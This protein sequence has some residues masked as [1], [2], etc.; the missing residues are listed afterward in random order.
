ME[1]RSARAAQLA[2]QV[3]EQTVSSVNVAAPLTVNAPIMGPTE[4]VR[5]VL[6]PP[7]TIRTFAA[8]ANFLAESYIKEIRSAWKTGDYSEADRL[9][10]INDS[11]SS[12]VQMQMRLRAPT[13]DPDELLQSILK[14]YGVHKTLSELE[15]EFYAVHQNSRESVED[16]FYRL[17]ALYEKIVQQ[18]R[19]QGVQRMSEATVRDRLSHN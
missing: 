13:N 4:V 16:Y 9:E 10:M 18:Q 12:R 19:E 15:A 2:D 11:M 5:Y 3:F 17:Y 6:M 14:F 1:T 8:E 7:Q